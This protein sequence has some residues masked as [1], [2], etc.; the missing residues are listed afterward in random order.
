M[1]LVKAAMSLWQKES[2][3]EKVWLYVKGW[4]KPC[5]KAKLSVTERFAPLSG[6]LCMH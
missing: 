6:S 1:G 5:S 3:L 2:A 4:E